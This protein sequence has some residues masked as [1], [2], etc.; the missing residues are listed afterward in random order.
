MSSQRHNLSAPLLSTLKMRPKYDRVSHAEARNID[1]CRQLKNKP[2]PWL[3]R[4][5]MHSVPRAHVLEAWLSIW[6]CEK[7]QGPVGDGLGWV[8]DVPDLR[9]S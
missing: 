1:F 9:K 3:D 5:W 2:V 7:R 8:T 6:Q 4:I